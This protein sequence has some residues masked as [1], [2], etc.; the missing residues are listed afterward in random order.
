M[1]A[2]CSP[3]RKRMS[4]NAGQI[5]VKSLFKDLSKANVLVRPYFPNNVPG[6][7]D[8]PLG[9]TLFSKVPTGLGDQ[10]ANMSPGLH[11]IRLFLSLAPI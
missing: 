6:S 2:E 8:G 4:S 9:Q 11:L 1:K 7:D 10:V 5:S 3:K